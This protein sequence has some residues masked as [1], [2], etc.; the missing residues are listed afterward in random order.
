MRTKIFN[1]YDIFMFDF[2]LALLLRSILLLTP[3]TLLFYQENGLTAQHL[4]FFQGIFYLTSI[5]SEIPVGYISDA[6]SR[7]YL[8]IISCLL[9]F[10]V[11]IC[12]INFHGY[13]VILCGEILFAIAKV[14][15]DNAMPGY[16]YDYL[17]K[18]KKPDAMVK[19]YGYLHF[20]L[21]LGTAIAAILGT[22]LYAKF[23][24]GKLLLTEAMFIFM[25][26]LLLLSLPTIKPAAK[27]IES[28]R[29]K[30]KEFIIN[31]KSLYSNESIK[32]HIIYS[33]LL[34]SLSILFSV[35]FQPL[36][37]N[38]FAPIFLFG[39]VAFSNHGIRALSGII[40]SKFL[41]KF[42]LHKLIRPLYLLYILAF[43]CVF[44]AIKLPSVFVVTF[45]I[46]V[47]C[48]I[49]GCQLI[50]TILHVSR[51]QKFVAMENRGNLMSIN[52]LI[53]RSLAAVMLISS[54][55]SIGKLDMFWYFG[56]FFVIYLI[57]CTYIM[58]K[59][60]NVKEEF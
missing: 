56:I 2:N 3:V 58:V 36:L 52:N 43:M 45:L 34:T 59:V 8:L 18:R 25:S 20:Y 55:F 44:A 57:I 22:F 19:Y 17:N 40:S 6:I 5:L 38:A 26:I 30:I 47:L 24:S 50:F 33:G 7:K 49:I 11:L 42:N 14:M 35:S 28:V 27:K 37:Q 54:K 1:R 31:T 10:T 46:F 29:S 13:Y 9:Y 15:L 53:S 23:G 12:W 60:Y 4:F 51:L 21:A 16:L 39:V 32:W 41:R 48:L